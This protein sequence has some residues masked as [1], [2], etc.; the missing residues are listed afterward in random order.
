MKKFLVIAFAFFLI[1]AIIDAILGGTLLFFAQHAKGG[2]TGRQNGIINKNR[3]NILVFGSSRAIHHYNAQMLSDSLST[4]CNNCGYDGMG[5]I[6]NYGQIQLIKKRYEP[7]VIIY[8]VIPDYD[9]LPDDKQ[10]YLRWLKPY[11]CPE[12]ED[13]FENVDKMQKYKMMS[14]LYRCNILFF[15]FIPDYLHPVKSMGS[16]GFRPVDEE[17]DTM[18]IIKKKESQIKENIVFDSLKIHYFDKL[19][20][21]IGKTT[22]VFVISP[23]W[24]KTDSTDTMRF[25]PIREICRQRNIPLIDFSNDSKYVGNDK[26]FKDGSHLNARG[27]DEFTHDLILELRKLKIKEIE[28]SGT[29][30]N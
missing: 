28:D 6:F 11:Y 22:L 1:L 29:Y 8:D 16:R 18:K 17:M 5:I 3:D 24:Y 7:N 2:D 25:A 10:K 27:A 26:Y 30:V 21:E 15:H 4:E 9:L 19:A 13:I 23:I 20:N 12:I 14:R